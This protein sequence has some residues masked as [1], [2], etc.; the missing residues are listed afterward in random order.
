MTLFYEYYRQDTLAT[1]YIPD[2]IKQ[3]SIEAQSDME[4]EN[5]Q[6]NLL[7]T[8]HKTLLRIEMQLES[9][10]DEVID[11]QEGRII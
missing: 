2:N 11:T 7:L 8:I 10:T 4:T 9:I 3:D 6:K 5:V 1:K